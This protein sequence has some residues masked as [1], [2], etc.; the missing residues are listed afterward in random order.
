MANQGKLCC[1]LNFYLL[2]SDLYNAVNIKQNTVISGLWL[3][4][5]QKLKAWAKENESIMD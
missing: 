3:E 2:A 1:M 4:H 5:K